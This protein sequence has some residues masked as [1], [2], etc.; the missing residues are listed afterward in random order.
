MMSPIEK[1]GKYTAR[2]IIRTMAAMM[3]FLEQ[4]LK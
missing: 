4:G 2:A 3:N 1:Y